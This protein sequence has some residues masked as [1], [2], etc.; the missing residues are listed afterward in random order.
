M[1]VALAGIAAIPT[2][3]I[4]GTD[5]LAM[6]ALGAGV[7]LFSVLGGW[8]VAKVAFRGPDRFATK[9]V[10]GGF[11]MRLMLLLMTMTVLVAVVGVE[12]SRFILWLVSFY[13]ALLMAEAWILARAN[14]S[15]PEEGPT[16]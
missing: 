13:F 12:L 6:L 11:L 16:R 7:A 10:V 3:K 14:V 15:D 9:L 1:T 2:V 8:F 4:G 5:E